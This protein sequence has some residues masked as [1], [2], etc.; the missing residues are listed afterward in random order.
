MDLTP[1][2]AE[3]LARIQLAHPDTTT[4]GPRV[5][6]ALLTSLEATRRANTE[7]ATLYARTAG[8]LFAARQEIRAL[9]GSEPPP[10]LAAEPG[11]YGSDHD[12]SHARMV[13]MDGSCS[14]C[15]LLRTLRT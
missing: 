6:A 14:A 5:T 7:L 9:R 11:D 2:Q 15:S 4:L 3:T 12:E 10:P 1:E 8:A 13:N